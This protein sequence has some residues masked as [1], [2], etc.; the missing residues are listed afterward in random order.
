VF[1]RIVV[2]V[3]GSQHALEAARQASLLQ[4]VDGSLTLFSASDSAEI[5][6]HVSGRLGRR[7][8]EEALAAAREHVELY[9]AVTTELVHGAPAA[10]LLRMIDRGDHTLVGLGAGGAGRR[11]GLVVGSVATEVMRRARCSVLVA[12]RAAG[13]F[14]RRIV[15]GVDGS[16]DSATVYAVSRYLAERFDAELHALVAT[17]GRAVDERLVA[18]ITDGEHDDLREPPAEA[19]IAASRAADLVVVGARGAPRPGPRVFEQV[20]HGAACS[21]LVVREAAGPEAGTEPGR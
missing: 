13:G 9:T 6:L 20:V 15:V 17:G 21:T 2:G 16:V 1:T 3:D 7:T 10:S 4:N 5:A 11:V 19:L 14:P 8:A 18:A 12:R